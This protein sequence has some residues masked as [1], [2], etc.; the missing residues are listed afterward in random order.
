M[1]MRNRVYLFDVDGTLT[2]PLTEINDE[3]ADIFLRWVHDKKRHVYLVTG[4]DIAKTKRQLFSSFIDQ[5]AGIF[6]CSG[7]V[8]YSKGRKIYEKKLELPDDFIDNLELYLE[9]GTSW[10]RKT[11]RH[12]EVRPGMVNFSTVGRNASPNLREAYGRWDFHSREREDIVDYIQG[13]YPDFEASIG[14]TISVDIYPAGCN[15][16]QVVE[17]IHEVHGTDVEMIFTGDRNVP[18]GNDWPLAQAL[19]KLPGSKWFQVES[20][21]ETRALIE[22]N[23]LFI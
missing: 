8:Y 21:A 10:R 18:G 17:K 11:G 12:I 9:H 5:C 2:P 13:I 14:G 3:F 20:P 1:A 7:N 4:S 23:E 6:T 16:A 22:G 19:E 15:K